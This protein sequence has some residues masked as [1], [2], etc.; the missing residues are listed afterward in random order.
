M[1]NF[2]DYYI[3]LEIPP[4]S[5]Q[6]AI[7]KAYRVL[8]KKFHPDLHPDKK[9]ATAKMQLI[10][11]AYL[12]L[13][14]AEAKALY[15]IEYKRYHAS[16][17]RQSQKAQPEQERQEYHYQSDVLTDWIA[18]ARRQAKD[19]TTQA[20]R[21]AGGIIKEAGNGFAQGMG[22]AIMWIIVFSFIFMLRQ[23]C[24]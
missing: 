11:E 19:I 8:V 24:K 16:R 18:K 17:R 14:D 22:R 13:S 6:D 9:D 12:I 3:V 5:S 4:D 15:D 20:I 21:D 10:N 7:K 1:R 2:I 23:G